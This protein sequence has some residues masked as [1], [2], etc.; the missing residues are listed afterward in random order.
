MASR[1]ALGEPLLSLSKNIV[2]VLGVLM[3]D[4][5]VQTLRLK[6]PS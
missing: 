1:R 5:I 4:T 6:L 2:G 3:P